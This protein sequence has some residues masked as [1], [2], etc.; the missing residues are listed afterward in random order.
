MFKSG[1]LHA[2]VWG[3]STSTL[4]PL[5]TGFIS[6]RQAM[7]SCDAICVCSLLYAGFTAVE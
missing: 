2:L 5:H 4:Y 6:G 3:T 1:Q 7:R